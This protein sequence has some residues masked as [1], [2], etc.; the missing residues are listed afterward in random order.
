VLKIRREAVE[1]VVRQGADPDSV[2][3]DIDYDARSAVLRATASGQTE[4]RERDLAQGGVGDE[5]RR[6]A[7]AKSLGVLP[8]EVE[9]AA[10][11]GLLRAYRAGLVRKR[12]FGLLRE[13][14]SA[15]AV[16]DEQAVVRLLLAGA[17]AVGFPVA[18]AREALPRLLETQTRYGDAGA[19]L[20]QLFLGLRGRIVNLSGLVD[21]AQVLSLAEAEIAGAPQDEVVLAVVAPRGA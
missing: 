12:L 2:S 8:G 7:A 17:E 21:R 11:A 15:V 6:S 16:V 5:E 9:L 4:L 13:C 3:V 10:E 18:Q 20:P 19:E 14:E 1:A